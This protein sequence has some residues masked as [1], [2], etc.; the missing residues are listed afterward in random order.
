[1]LVAPSDDSLL[2]FGGLS[3]AQNP[4]IVKLNL[5]SGDEMKVNFVVPDQSRLTKEVASRSG[6]G[7]CCHNGSVFYFFG[8]LLDKHTQ[9]RQATNEAIRYDIGS[10]QLT[11]KHLLHE[12]DR[13][14]M[15]RK[16]FASAQIG[17]DWLCFGGTDLTG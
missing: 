2:L 1:V 16:N 11:H 8:D 17:K 10:N 4:R 5:L 15:P 13:L 14:L 12:P 3:S 9:S 6:F 7:G